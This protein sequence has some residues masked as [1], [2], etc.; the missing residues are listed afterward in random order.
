M[1]KTPEKYAALENAVNRLASE[2][3]LATVGRDDGLVPAYSLVGELSELCADHPSLHTPVKA[4]LVEL[5]KSLDTAQPFSEALLGRLRSTVE[6]LGRAIDSVRNDAVVAPCPGFEHAAPA[7]GSTGVAVPAKSEKTDV[8]MA[9]ELEENQE[10]L[11]EFHA[12]VV[13]HLQQIEAA[14]L[15]LDQQPDNPEALNSIFR[16]FHTIKGNAGF[17]GLVPMHTLAHEVE[18]LLDLARTNKLALNTAIITEIL[19]SRDA[20]QALTQQCATA[21][22]TGKLPDQVV[23]VAHLIRAVKKVAGLGAT[24]APFSFDPQPVPVSPSPLAKTAAP[25][26]A[27]KPLEPLAPRA[28]SAP[29]PA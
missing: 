22:E 17:L 14:L 16:S 21:L 18:S 5:E 10:L 8:L 12:E 26:F 20:L 4:L 7:A 29:P 9:F 23:P 15:Q 1:P 28:T 2:A 13:D 24:V 19:R 3:M 27:E 25:D 6:W 11:T